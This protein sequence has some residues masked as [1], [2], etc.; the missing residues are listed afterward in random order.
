MLPLPLLP[1]HLQPWKNSGENEEG[2]SLTVMLAIAHTMASH[3]GLASPLFS[4][5]EHG[6]R[7]EMAARL[8]RRRLGNKSADGGCFARFGTKVQVVGAV[9][10]D[11]VL[12]RPPQ[13]QRNAAQRNATARLQRRRVAVSQRAAG[14]C[15]GCR[16]DREKAKRSLGFARGRDGG[17]RQR[18]SQAAPLIG[19]SLGVAPGQKH[20]CRMP[21]TPDRSQKETPDS[22]LRNSKLKTRKKGQTKIRPVK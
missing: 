10:L 5:N 7:L 8:S 13:T 14:G 11:V 4:V 17:S 18:G 20:R 15:R 2:K 9:V 6:G 12:C 21:K 16:A 22:S 19:S 1:T 3:T